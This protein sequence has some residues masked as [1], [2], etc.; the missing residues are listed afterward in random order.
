VIV[1]QSHKIQTLTINLF[2]FVVELEIKISTMNV[3]ME[4]SCNFMKGYEGDNHVQK[5]KM[6]TT[7]KLQLH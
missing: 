5:G 2:S 7:S 6:A 1:L 3:G 4:Y